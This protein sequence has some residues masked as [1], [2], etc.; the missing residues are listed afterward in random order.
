LLTLIGGW[1]FAETYARTRSMRLVWLEHALYGCLVFT[2][3]LGDYFYHG[4]VS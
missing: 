1:F 4:N 2:I 3:G